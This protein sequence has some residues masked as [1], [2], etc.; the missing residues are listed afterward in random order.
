VRPYG[1]TI[2]WG[3]VPLDLVDTPER[4]EMAFR[5]GDEGLMLNGQSVPPCR[6]VCGAADVT[7]RRLQRF[8]VE[9]GKRYLWRNVRVATGQLLQAGTIQPDE[10]GLLT[11]PQFL[12][13]RDVRGNK[14]ILE[15]L[16]GRQV[17]AVDR[18][19]KV[20]I[21]WFRTR[22]DRH[23]DRNAQT[24]E[25]PYDTYV[26]RCLAPEL[27]PVVRPDKVFRID[28]FVNARGFRGGG[29]YSQWGGGFDD[30]YEFPQAGRYR[31]EVETTKAL[32]QNGAWPILGLSVDS[33][34]VGERLL[35]SEQT[36]TRTWWVDLSKGRHTVR[37]WLMN[38][39]FNEPVPRNGDQSPKPDRGFSL[40]GVRFVH[41]EERP[42]TVTK[43]HQVTVTPRSAVTCAG[44][45]VRLRA[46]V[47]CPWGETPMPRR[48]EWTATRGATVTPDGVF[49]AA[50]AGAYTVMAA[51]GGKSDSVTVQV[52]G[53]TWVDDF[54]DEWPDGWAVVPPA[55]DAKEKPKWMVTRHHGFIGVL[56]QRNVRAPGPHLILY[57]GGA[58]WRDVSVQ[59]DVLREGEGI[60]KG[61]AQGIAFGCRDAGNHC[62]FE[63][64][65]GED[66]AKFRLV[67]VVGGREEELARAARE[68]APLRVPR[69][70]YPSCRLW[71]ERRRQDPKPVEFDRLQI[72]LRGGRIA[73][74][75]NGQEVLTAQDDALQ[76]GTIGLWCLGGAAFDNVNVQPV[77]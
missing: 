20:A 53:D 30:A 47:Q 76:G 15:P 10:H 32:F 75:C 9:T 31:I 74:K 2:R 77:R 37:F 50:K 55:P 16:Q 56:A 65:A 58:T 66:G 70:E 8:Q 59:V 23:H 7:P 68:V 39:V 28:D 52:R 49:S 46:D 73:A 17:P 11:V 48:P 4:F 54:D 62:R 44:L 26:T 51:V 24:E 22:T 67:K 1:G 60:A 19:Q 14:L 18:T 29:L 5:I 12:V 45:P 25:L 21:T 35:D 71:S 36:I 64:H 43:V 38:N 72:E 33:R 40:V 61:S 6:V 3:A 34:P 63:R 41:L 57:E 27:V 42:E 13:D 69:S